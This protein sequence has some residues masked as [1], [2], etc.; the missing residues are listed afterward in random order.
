MT[1]VGLQPWLPWPL[2]RW[3]WLTRPVPAERLAALRIGLAAVMLF[4][5]LVAYLPVRA[6]L[7]GLESLGGPDRR[8]LGPWPGSTWTLFDDSSS[9]EVLLAL[10][11]WALA[12]VGLL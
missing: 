12:S 11:A 9:D 3:D 7:F 4:D 1:L 6:D 8:S 10:V 2:S 5:V